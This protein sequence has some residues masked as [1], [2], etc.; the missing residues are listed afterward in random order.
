MHTRK[1]SDSDITILCIDDENIH[2][3]LNKMHIV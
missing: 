2:P 1:I 3:K